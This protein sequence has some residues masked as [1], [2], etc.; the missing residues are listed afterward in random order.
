MMMSSRYCSMS[1]LVIQGRFGFPQNTASGKG[2]QGGI[3]SAG[4]QSFCQQ[5]DVVIFLIFL[6]VAKVSFY[7]KNQLEVLEL[8][9]LI[10]G[11]G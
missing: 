9:C 7:P 10:I 8:H 2:T 5:D 3:G 6:T 4:Q 11:K 1:P